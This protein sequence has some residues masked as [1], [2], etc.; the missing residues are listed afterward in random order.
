MKVLSHILWLL[1]FWA[2]AIGQPFPARSLAG[3]VSAS[4]GPTAV[5]LPA[6]SQNP[7]ADPPVELPIRAAFYYPWFPEAWEQQ[8]FSPFTQYSPSDGFYA[9]TDT[10]TL[11]KQ[12]EAM[13][14]GHI[15]AGIASWWGQGSRTDTRIDALLAAAKG[16]G[17]S[18]SLYIES[19]NQ[20]NPTVE[21]IR[22][23]LL[24]IRDRYASHPAFLNI[25][26]RF[27]LF[28]YSDSADG[29]DMVDRWKQANTVG[30]YLVL[31]VFPGYAQCPSQPDGWHQYAPAQSRDGQGADSF[32]ISPGF[33]KAGEAPRLERD[34]ERW[35]A[36]AQA[37]IQS[38]ARFQLITTFNEWGEGTAVESAQEWSSASGYGQYLDVLHEVA[39]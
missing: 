30:A 15:Q 2:G 37:M 36:D 14:Y 26:H 16:T 3:Q 20:G 35:K 4:T 21:Q 17:F 32:S 24:Y 6:I 22:Q 33:W 39:P 10:A 12:I 1:S 29:C 7:T 13:Q 8:G 34:L 31:K 38:G 28:V 18:W 11:Q 25:D 27:V 23:D 9:T 5:F 19:E